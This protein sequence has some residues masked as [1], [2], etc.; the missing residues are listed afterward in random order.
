MNI[1]NITGSSIVTNADTN[2]KSLG[3]P[4]N[5][6]FEQQSAL[7]MQS[8]TGFAKT[9][10]LDLAEDCWDSISLPPFAQVSLPV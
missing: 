6:T 10:L 3:T 9:V 5:L 7:I 2:K 4:S 1:S 8:H